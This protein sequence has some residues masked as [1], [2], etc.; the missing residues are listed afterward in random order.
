MNVR[1]KRSVQL[2]RFFY[3][4]FGALLF[5]YF[6]NLIS[7]GIENNI[8]DYY[9]LVS[10]WLMII[11]FILCLIFGYNFQWFDSFLFDLLIFFCCIIGFSLLGFLV[12]GYNLPMIFIVWFV[13]DNFRCIIWCLIFDFWIILFLAVLAACFGGGMY[14]CH[15]FWF[16]VD[17]FFCG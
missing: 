9:I 3:K 6:Y 1:L 4:F 11:W 13:F 7:F 17:C 15:C 2:R 14:F 5:A 16:G 10:F 8:F 12:F